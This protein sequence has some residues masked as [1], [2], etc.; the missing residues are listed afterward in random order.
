MTLTFFSEQWCAEA[1]RVVNADD[2]IREGLVDASGFDVPLMFECSDHAGVGSRMEFVGGEATAWT[3]GTD[4]GVVDRTG[5]TFSASLE[6]W[7]GVAE[8]ERD[9]SLLLMERKLR[10][11]DTKRQAM[12]ANYRAVDALFKSWGELATD[13]NL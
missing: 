7:R 13:W 6:I 3:S 12:A 2:A 10:L 5:A 11:K 4:W 8:G 9:A 1:L